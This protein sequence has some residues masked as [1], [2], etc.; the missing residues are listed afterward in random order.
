MAFRIAVLSDPHL[1]PTSSPGLGELASKRVLGWAN[2]KRRRHLIHDPE[3]LSAITTDLKAQRPDHIVVAGDLTNLA[4]PA[5]ISAAR[6]WLDSLGPAHDVTVIPGNHDAYVPGALSAVIQSWAPYL[7]SDNGRVGFPVLRQRGPVLL[8]GLSSAIASP[9]FR[10]TGRV[11][12]AQLDELVGALA[13]ENAFRLVAIHHPVVM[14]GHNAK[15][16]LNGNEVCE[17]LRRA[18][19]DMV[20]HGHMHTPM[21][22]MLPGTIPMWGVPSASAKPDQS[23]DPAEYLIIDVEDAHVVITRRGFDRAG[24]LSMR[25]TKRMVLQR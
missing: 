9:P 2:W 12:R 17:A 7:T 3:T 10:A 1:R 11:S 19:A 18:G 23:Q 25:A 14:A 5:E 15:R 21:Q 4:L 24:M 8:A 20:V 6:H 13:H 22:T 16:L